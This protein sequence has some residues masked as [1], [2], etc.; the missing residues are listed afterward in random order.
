MK[1]IPIF[2]FLFA[3]LVCDPASAK[4]LN[5]R[6]SMSDGSPSAA[7]QAPDGSAVSFLFDRFIVGHGQ[8]QSPEKS[9]TILFNSPK[10]PATGYTL[11][12]VRGFVTAR[13]GTRVTLNI[14]HEGRNHRFRLRSK[15]GG[16]FTK[17]IRI[18]RKTVDPVVL[19]V[20]L[21]SVQWIKGNEGDTGGIDSIDVTFK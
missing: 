21:E 11:L 20:K 7:T 5:A 19:S 2:L 10:S 16:D 17:D 15:T 6:V 14:M 3:I 8:G 18:K 13:F 9:A 12:N 1:R 4:D